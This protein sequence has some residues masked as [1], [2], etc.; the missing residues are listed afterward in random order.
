M[1]APQQAPVQQIEAFQPCKSGI[2]VCANGNICCKTASETQTTCRPQNYCNLPDN[3]VLKVVF[4][5]PSEN[6]AQTS[7]APANGAQTSQMSVAPDNTVRLVPNWITC[8][9]NDKCASASW[10]CCVAPGDFGKRGGFNGQDKSTCRPQGD[11]HG[12]A[13]PIQVQQKNAVSNN[14]PPPP[15]LMRK[16]QVQNNQAVTPV[17]SKDEYLKRALA[18]VPLPVTN[19]FNQDCLDTHNIFRQMMGRNGLVWDT[20]LANQAQ[21]YSDYLATYNKFEHSH[22]SLPQFGMLGEN[23]YRVTNGKLDCASGVKAWMDEYNLYPTGTKVGDG[24]FK[25]YGHF[26]ELM[27][28]NLSKIGCARTFYN[29]NTQVLV[30]NYDLVQASGVVLDMTV[31]NPKPFG[32]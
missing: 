20:A 12:D 18:T 7:A 31:P 17:E 4:L 8:S 30:C 9:A 1:S 3:V 29:G 28:P 16:I 10:R 27:L 2:D 32:L 15:V 24:D 21:K 6:G 23:L 25:G 14:T 11:C 19:N 13:K 22:A 26:T 5:E